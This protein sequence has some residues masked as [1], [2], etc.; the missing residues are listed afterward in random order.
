M[1]RVHHLASIQSLRMMRQRRVRPKNVIFII[2]SNWQ[3]MIPVYTNDD[4]SDNKMVMLVIITTIMVMILIVK[5]VM[6]TMV[7]TMHVRSW[8]TC[9]LI[10]SGNRFDAIICPSLFFQTIWCSL[11]DRVE[12]STRWKIWP[13]LQI[14]LTLFFFVCKVYR[15]WIAYPSLIFKAS[16]V[17]KKV[18]VTTVVRTVGYPDQN[19]VKICHHHSVQPA[20]PPPLRS[21]STWSGTRIWRTRTRTTPRCSELWHGQLM[22]QTSRLRDMSPSM[23]IS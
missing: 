13:A 3:P 14:P 7:F 22:M 8:G 12:N 19:H 20:A 18:F 23:S 9:G 21:R 5:I 2:S 4:A 1:R 10:H 16:L 15:K 11:A 17:C 6:I